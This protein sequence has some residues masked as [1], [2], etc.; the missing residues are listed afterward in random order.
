M[1]FDCASFFLRNTDAS[2]DNIDAKCTKLVIKILDWILNRERCVWLRGVVGGISTNEN[3]IPP[4]YQ[5]IDK[6]ARLI[7]RL[8]FGFGSD[9]VFDKL[10]KCRALLPQITAYEL[11][12]PST[13]SYFN[14][15]G[16]DF[17]VS[18]S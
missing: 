17:F 7:I 16:I 9:S 10:K 13:F 4:L 14:S 6:P 12:R 18:K 8:L 11:V 1:E 2:I 15:F 5:E 3:E